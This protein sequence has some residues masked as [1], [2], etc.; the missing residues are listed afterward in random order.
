MDKFADIFSENNNGVVDLS[1]GDYNPL[2]LKYS[3]VFRTSLHKVKMSYGRVLP[4]YSLSNNPPF[5]AACDKVRNFTSPDNIR[6]VLRRRLKKVY[7]D[8]RPQSF[9]DFFGIDFSSQQLQLC[10]PWAGVLPW[11]ARSLDGYRERV[12]EGTLHDNLKQGYPGMGIDKGW[13]SCGPVSKEKLDIEVERLALLINS[14]RLCGYKR[15]FS[16]DGDIVAT[17]L[18]GE[19]YD[20]RWLVTSGHH[21][22]CVVASLGYEDLKVRVNSV[23]LRSEYMFW[24]HVIDGLYTPAEALSVFDTIYK[25]IK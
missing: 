21:R 24:P 14:V 16:E 22:A 23:V 15:S 10:E 4:G 25:G 9:S 13:A 19:N 5:K 3:E 7:E 1:H 6:Y 20:W 2:L 12:M 11:R 8:Y 18:I 17:A